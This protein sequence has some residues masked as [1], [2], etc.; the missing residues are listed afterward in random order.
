MEAAVLEDSQRIVGLSDLILRGYG[1]ELTKDA[2]ILDFGC[3]SGRHT[4]EYLDAGYNHAVGFDVQNYVRLRDP[5]D[6]CHFLV[7]GDDAGYR[8]PADSGSF[9]FVVSISVFEHVQN[10][11][12]AIAEIG[13]VLKPGGATLHVFPSRW[14]P[15]EPHIM[16]PFGGILQ[17]E[18]WLSIWARL[19][20]RN[21]YQRDLSARETVAK[22]LA[23]CKN[24]IKYLNTNAIRHLWKTTF[25]DVH[26][27]EQAYLGGTRSVSSISKAAWPLAKTI[28]GLDCL[29]RSF[30][31]RAVLAINPKG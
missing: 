25:A 19:G 13:R 5:V 14:R 3:G 26:F 9:D 10:Q 22:N 12:D 7:Q 2:H 28:P 17:N 15:I 30:H 29:Y 18:F 20:V 11:A 31:T 27:V 4:Y 21:E 1:I 16:V 24:G 6:R 8:I 23:Y